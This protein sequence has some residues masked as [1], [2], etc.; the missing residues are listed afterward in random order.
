LLLSRYAAA[1]DMETR[2]EMINA[3]ASRPAFATNLL[4]A[5]HRG[6]IPRRDVGP[7]QVRQLRSLKEPDIDSRVAALWPQFDDSPSAKRELLTRYKEL[8][9]PARLQAADPSAGR[10]V[11][12]QACAVCHTLFGEGAKIGPEL[13]GADR[14]NLDYLLQNILDPSAVVPEN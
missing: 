3:L 9:V 1:P 5:V 13:T 8:L 11:F 4:D 7:T 10:Q 14:R 2:T 6:V 12:K